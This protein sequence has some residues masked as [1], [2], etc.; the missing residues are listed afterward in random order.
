M[1]ETA[2]QREKE[3][4]LRKLIEAS[5]PGLALHKLH[6]AAAVDWYGVRDS[7]IVAFYELKRRA[8]PVDKYPTV[9][10]SWR[11]W[12]TLQLTALAFGVPGVFVV[13]FADSLRW[14]DVRKVSGALSLAGRTDRG[15]ENDIEPIIEVPVESMAVLET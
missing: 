5:R 12:I 4:A 2:E 1:L 11:K 8:H 9:F 3:E 7:R 6:G 15:L 14:I 10:M 13:Q